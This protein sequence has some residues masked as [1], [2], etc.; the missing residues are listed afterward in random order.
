MSFRLISAT[1]PEGM[2][3]TLVPLVE[4]TGAARVHVT[5]PGEDGLQTAEILA[6]SVLAQEVTDGLQTLLGSC[7]TWRVV[8]LPVEAALP[9]LPEEVAKDLDGRRRTASREALRNSVAQGARLDTDYLLLTMLATVVAAIGLN[10]D[11]VAVVIG[12]MVI[13]PL[14]GPQIAFGF[15]ATLGDPGLMARAARTGIAGFAVALALSAVIGLAVGADMESR[16]LMNRT[17]VGLADI[18]LALA[19][20]AAAALSITAGVSSALVG[21]MVAVAL[22]PPTSAIGLLAADGHWGDAWNAA[23]LLATNLVCVHLSALAVLVYK[24]VRPRTWLEQDAARK[25]VRITLVVWA[26]LLAFLVAL[27]LSAGG[28]PA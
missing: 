17:T 5:P 7:E 18:A 10:A 28:R 26:T 13:A 25:A 1:F 23:L 6:P 11:N 21:V 24:G 16:E 22:L 12:A 19:S 15:G 4:K 9:D 27:L 20:G 8:V 14:L 3:D 2:G